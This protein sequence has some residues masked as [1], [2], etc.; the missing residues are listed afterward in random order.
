VPLAA[1]RRVTYAEYLARERAS[2]TKHEYIA[3]EIVAMAG[4]TIEHG[5]LAARFAGLVY[6]ALA[7]RPCDTFSSDVRVRVPDGDAYYP[8]LTVVCGRLERDA[9]DSDAITNPTV[10]VEVL[11]PST[12]ARDRG[13]KFHR[14]R[15]LSSLR[16]YVLVYQEEALVEVWRLEDRRWTLAQEATAGTTLELAS[17]GARISVDDLYSQPLP[18]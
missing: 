9:E 2:D 12:E 10:I 15:R 11:S 7:G 4:G 13:P 3:G 6:T 14:Y 8:D 1:K 17:V 16:E 5:R 18:A